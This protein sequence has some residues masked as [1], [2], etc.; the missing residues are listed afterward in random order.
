MK[1]NSRPHKRYDAMEAYMYQSALAAAARLV[2]RPEFP[3]AD[4]CSAIILQTQQ[5]WMHAASAYDSLKLAKIR[6]EINYPGGIV[7]NIL[8][9]LDVSPD[10]FLSRLETA[11]PM[12]CNKPTRRKKGSNVI[13]L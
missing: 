10:E 5:G 7:A 12:G 11:Y 4:L 13:E 8:E 2:A 1:R 6:A 3:L 9:C